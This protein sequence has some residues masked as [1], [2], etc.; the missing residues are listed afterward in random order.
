[1]EFFNFAHMIYLKLF[2]VFSTRSMLIRISFQISLSL[3]VVF[4]A[5]ASIM[6]LRSS[7]NP[8]R[9]ACFGDEVALIFTLSFPVINIYNN[10]YDNIY[11]F[12]QTE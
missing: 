10:I 12:F 11:V 3:S 5:G 8:L 4:D 6:R 1:M 9:F 7:R 2:I